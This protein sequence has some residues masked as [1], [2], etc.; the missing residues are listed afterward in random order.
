MLSDSTHAVSP[1][2]HLRDLADPLLKLC[3]L[4]LLQAPLSKLPLLL[5]LDLELQELRVK[6]LLLHSL[7][8]LLWGL[9]GRDFVQTLILL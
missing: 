7:L 6:L 3:L 1:P 5:L 8:S 9:Q 4:F 2:E